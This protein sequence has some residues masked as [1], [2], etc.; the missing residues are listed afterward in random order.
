MSKFIKFI[1]MAVDGQMIN[2]LFPY[3]A[4]PEV[5]FVFKHVKDIHGC[6]GFTCHS[7]NSS[8]CPVSD[9]DRPIFSRLTALQRLGSLEGMHV[10]FKDSHYLMLVEQ[11][12]P[13]KKRI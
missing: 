7:E 12:N 11:R 1:P 10:I 4:D 6:I 5:I 2:L 9:V 13:M 8:I 3:F